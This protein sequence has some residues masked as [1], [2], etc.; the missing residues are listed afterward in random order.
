[1]LQHHGLL[2]QAYRFYNHCITLF[3]RLEKE[4]NSFSLEN[5]SF[6]AKQILQNI[7]R[8]FIPSNL[9]LTVKT[10]QSKTHLNIVKKKAICLQCERECY[11]LPPN[12]S[13]EIFDNGFATLIWCQ[14]CGHGGHVECMNEWYDE[15]KL[16]HLN[17]V[18]MMTRCQHFCNPILL[19]VNLVELEDRSGLSTGPMF[20]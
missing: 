3:S 8:H 15:C 6:D 17:H 12:A 4:Q 11:K 10:W 13:R 1:M 14:T 20:Q 2:R 19:R 5:D 9:R 18:C 16:N 7:Q